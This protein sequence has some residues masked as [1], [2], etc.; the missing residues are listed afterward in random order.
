MSNRGAYSTK[1]RMPSDRKQSLSLPAWKAVH[2]WLSA[3]YCPPGSRLIMGLYPA[4]PRFTRMYGA[5][6]SIA[7][8]AI[9]NIT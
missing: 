8:Q 6:N 2:N 3:M 9:S 1:E 5:T 7:F 4:H